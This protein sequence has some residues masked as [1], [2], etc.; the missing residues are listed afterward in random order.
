MKKETFKVNGEVLLE[1]IRELINEGNVRKITITDK[2]GKEL[3]V[4]SL[5]IG[6]VGAIL[7]PILIAVGAVAALVGECTIS[8][9][10]EEGGEEHEV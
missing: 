1:K 7:A 6:V 4:F 8:V 9:E 10:R 3:M 5:T 2:N